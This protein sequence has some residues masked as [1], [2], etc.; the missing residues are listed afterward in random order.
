MFHLKE[1]L[2]TITNQKKKPQRRTVKTHIKQ[3][4]EGKEHGKE[5][6]A[7]TCT[8]TRKEDEKTLNNPYLIR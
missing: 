6:P 8:G 7:Y 1:E 2:G 4:G 5:E 3:R